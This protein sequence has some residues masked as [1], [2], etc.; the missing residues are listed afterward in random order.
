MSLL[1][2]TGFA[3]WASLLDSVVF[4]FEITPNQSSSNPDANCLRDWREKKLGP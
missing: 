4:S 3:K 2:L 1:K